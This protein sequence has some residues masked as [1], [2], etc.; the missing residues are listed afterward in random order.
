MFQSSGIWIWWYLHGCI[1]PVHI[2]V[3]RLTCSFLGFLYYW[4]G[5]LQ[6]MGSMD[7]LKCHRWTSM[8]FS[9]I[10]SCTICQLYSKDNHFQC[11]SLFM[12]SL[13]HLET[14]RFLHV[15]NV[16]VCISC[17][18]YSNTGLNSV[19]AIICWPREVTLDAWKVCVQI[20]TFFPV[21]KV[22]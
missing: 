1:F 13:F 7:R 17:L 15:D 10:F 9:E 4:M 21:E 18:L 2:I 8:D 19:V 20:Q 12:I 3:S 16:Q 11:Y 14:V 6:W 22:T 5:E